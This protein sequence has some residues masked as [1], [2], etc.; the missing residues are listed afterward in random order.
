MEPEVRDEVFPPKTTNSSP[1]Q[2]PEA[3]YLGGRA[4]ETSIVDQA[5]VTESQTAPSPRMSPVLLRPPQIIMRCPSQALTCPIRPENP[6]GAAK[7]VQVPGTP[8]ALN[9]S[10]A[11]DAQCPVFE[12]PPHTI[13]A[14][15]VQII[16][17]PILAPGGAPFTGIG[18]QLFATGS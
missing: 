17:A 10:T 1:V 14:L 7:L 12:K 16:V 5:P 15:P 3:S 2:A 4:P 18:D 6:E 11:P 8:C 9:G 13:R